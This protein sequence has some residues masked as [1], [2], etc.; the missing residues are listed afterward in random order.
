MALR[1]SSRGTLDTYPHCWSRSNLT[2]LPTWKN[3]LSGFENFGSIF[4]EE[5]SKTLLIFSSVNFGLFE[6]GQV[7]F[8]LSPAR[9]VQKC[10]KN[11]NLTS[12]RKQKVTLDT[13]WQPASKFGSE[14]VNLDFLSFQ[15]Q[16]CKSCNWESNQLIE[17]CP[18][19]YFFAYQTPI[20]WNSSVDTQSK[21]FFRYVSYV[22]PSTSST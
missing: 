22:D 21:S 8:F 10:N 18:E 15:W 9:S 11:N 12:E 4:V 17:I 20:R 14:T 16:Y 6:K 19:N 2:Q 5:A 1:L 3:C 7:T 13:N